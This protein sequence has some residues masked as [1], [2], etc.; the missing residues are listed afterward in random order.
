MRDSD[1]VNILLVDDQPAKLL[2]YEVILG[3]LGEN[4][5]KANSA[6]EALE[7]VLKNDVGVI[8]VDVCMPEL[9]GFELAQMLRDHP[10]YENTAI[11]FISAVHL[12]DLDRV[13]GYQMGAV[14]YVPVP[15]IPEILKAK[16]KI[17]AELYRKTRQLERLNNELESR[18]SE[19]TAALEASSSQ[20]R[21]S[22]E[23]LH[24]ASEA[25]GFGTYD[26]NSAAE[27]VY[28]SPYLR[29]MVGLE[30][31]DPLTLDQALE[32]IHPDHREMLRDHIQ[33]YAPGGRRELEF[34][35]VQPDGEI[36]WL[37]DRGQA[38]TDQSASPQDWRIMGTILDITERK[39]SEERQRLLMAEL[40]H[41]VKNIL[42]NVSAIAHLSS[43]RAASVKAFV[44]SLDGRIQAMSRA[45]GLL[46]RGAWVGASLLDLTTEA[47]SPFRSNAAN[48]IEI[49]GPSVSIVPELAQSMV[50][51]LHELATNAVKH[52]ALSVPGGQVKVAWSR[53]TPGQLE[54]IWTEAGGPTVE[55]PSAKGFGLTV[56]M[57]AAASLDAVADCDFRPDGFVY[58]LRG[59]LEQVK[60]PPPGALGTGASGQAPGLE[61]GEDTTP[62]RILVV[63]DE[64]LVALQIQ[65][66]LEQEG[67][68]VVGPAR[69][70]KQG[71]QLAAQEDIDA[72]LIDVSLGRDV[73][74]PIA[75]KLLARSIPFAFAT[76][77]S[78]PAMLPEHLRTVPRVSKPYAIAEIRHVLDT[79]IADRTAD[80]ERPR[81]VRKGG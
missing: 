11:I 27:H 71:L 30:G 25:A 46:R 13:R 34:K 64:A 22:A 45:H 12:S 47:L 15:V 52:G 78:D 33:S 79:L 49:D 75:D 1:P 61:A 55:T 35:I 7:F 37:L 20:L 76:G 51:I 32:V 14:D 5:F 67:H 62:R 77:Y 56:L 59:P 69:S 66:D 58:T 81:R 40:D 80:E 54:L 10:R 36:R 18:V 43:H 72:A 8:L 57:T 60:I 63:E 29:S 21:E 19:R 65:G 68:E 16:V 70:L 50:L 23:R 39:Q 6:R 38:V 9:D 28:W 17:F 41:R 31:D 26:Y 48:N 4:L 3:D 74:I 42:S 2:S 24:L 53:P 44:K 73:S